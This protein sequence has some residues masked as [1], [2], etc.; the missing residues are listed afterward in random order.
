MRRRGDFVS[1]R[2][3]VSAWFGALELS[4]DFD[5]FRARF[6][7]LYGS[8]DKQSLRSP[9][10]GFRCH[11]GKSAIR[12]RRYQ[13]LDPPGDAAGRRRRRDAVRSATACSTDL[14]SSKDE[15]QSNFTNPGM[16]LAGIGADFDLLP[17]LRFA[18]NFNDLSFADTEVLDVLRAIRRASR[19]HI[20]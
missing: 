10:D 9:R 13:L 8:G 4:R 12:R 16:L 2:D 19:K 5:W 18:V 14:R 11:P 3:N 6:S 17:Q 15:G 7:L 1:G 20:G